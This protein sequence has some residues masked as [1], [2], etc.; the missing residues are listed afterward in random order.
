MLQD[1]EQYRSMNGLA[2]RPAKSRWQGLFQVSLGLFLCLTIW[3]VWAGLALYTAY[4]YLT[5]CD[6]QAIARAGQIGDLFGG[7]NALFTGLSLA[8]LVYTIVLQNRQIQFSLDQ[9]TKSQNVQSIIELRNVL[10]DEAT[11]Q[12]RAHVQ[13][14]RKADPKVWTKQDL[15]AAERFCHTYEFAGV[16]VKNGLISEHLIFDTWGGS[17]E[18]CW[19]KLEAFLRKDPRGYKLK[20]AQFEILAARY[21]IWKA[22]QQIDSASQTGTN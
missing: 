20:Y 12:A 17:I 7:I 21:K 6:N 5:N 8:G 14:Q 18:R 4:R 19:E 16:L 9:F 13:N 1:G 15:A 22:N 11:R 3:A 2:T 10:Q